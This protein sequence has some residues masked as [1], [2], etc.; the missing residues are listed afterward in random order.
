MCDLVKGGVKKN[1]KEIKK[2]VI[3]PK[4]IC[5]ECGRVSNNKN[6]LCED[7]KLNLTTKKK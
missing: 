7:I 5:K 2:I 6:R 1:L 4:Y 3:N